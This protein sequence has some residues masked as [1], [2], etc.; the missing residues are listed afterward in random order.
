LQVSVSAVS[1]FRPGFRGRY[2]IHYR[3]S[4][5][6]ALTP[7]IY[8]LPD[9]ST[10]YDSSSV[11]PDFSA[12][13]SVMW[14]LPTLNPFDEGNIVV[15]VAI[16]STSSFGDTIHSISYIEPVTGDSYPDDNADTSATRLT[17]S[18]DPND[19]SVNRSSILTT[20]LTTQYLE[21]TIRF[22]NTGNDTAF[23]VRINNPLTDKFDPS[24]FEFLESSHPA[25]VNYTSNDNTLWFEMNNILLPDS[26][27]HQEGS[28]GFVKYRIKASPLL[29]AGETIYNEAY[30]YFD[31]NPAVATNSVSTHV[32]L[33]TSI[34]QIQSGPELSLYPNPTTGDVT[35]MFNLEHSSHVK[36]DLYN[37]QGTKIK[38]IDQNMLTRGY[39]QS[40][41]SFSDLPIGIY[42]IQLVIDSK[43]VTK[44]VVV[45]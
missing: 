18:F 19:I 29:T 1:A 35:V 12:T 5:T 42:L 21:Y 11:V 3:N 44:R 36:F 45:M 26:N 22:Q 31:Y 8:F 32:L 14:N 34:K 28:H 30:I 6:T 2:S 37:S 41:L 16:H 43:V 27:V 10:S 39:H 23:T 38:S 7:T 17:G 4:G 24:T 15:W 13:D 40:L 9:S 25:S 33:P 20:E